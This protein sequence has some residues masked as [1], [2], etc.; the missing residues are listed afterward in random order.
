[1][2]RIWY[3]LSGGN[4]MG[5]FD[6]NEARSRIAD[7]RSTLVWK[8]GMQQWAPAGQIPEFT[9]HQADFA[10]HAPKPSQHESKLV[11]TPSTVIV[12]F[13]LSF[14]FGI[15]GL[16]VCAIGYSEAER[17]GKGTGLAIAGMIIGLLN[18]LDWG[19]F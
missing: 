17:R 2:K 4:R 16:I 19:P 11:S 6:L 8:A 1:M 5:P 14:F 3:I 15:A 12:G 9:L 7:L 13:V 18:F 10:P